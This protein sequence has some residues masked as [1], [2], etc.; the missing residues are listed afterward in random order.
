MLSAGVAFLISQHVL[1]WLEANS[2]LTM[3]EELQGVAVALMLGVVTDYSVFYFTS[4]REA[5]RDGLPGMPFPA[6]R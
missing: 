2:S 4:A 3:P 6:P 5:F 1:G